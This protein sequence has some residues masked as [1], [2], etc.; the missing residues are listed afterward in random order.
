[1]SRAIALEAAG[2]CLRLAVQPMHVRS[3]LSEDHAGSE[4]LERRQA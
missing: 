2:Q 1:M 4:V 3:L